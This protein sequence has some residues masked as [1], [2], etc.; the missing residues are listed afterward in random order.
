MDLSKPSK[1]LAR[2]HRWFKELDG[3][4]EFTQPQHEWGVLRPP[5]YG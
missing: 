5:E 3:V 1:I 2:Y 4:V